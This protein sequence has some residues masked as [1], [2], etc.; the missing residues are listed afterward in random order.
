MTSPRVV[1]DLDKIDHNA[2]ALVVR[3]ARSGISVSGVTKAVLADPEIAGVLLRAGVQGLGD[4]HIENIE[5]LRRAHGQSEIT[6]IRTPMISQADRIVAHADISFNT[7]LAVIAAL[8]SAAQEQSKTHG[9]VLMVELGD[10]REGV[11]P[12]NLLAAVEA[13]RRFPNIVFKGIGAN[14]ACLNGVVPGASNMAE[15]SSLADKIDAKF[16][17]I[18]EIV[19]GGNSANINWAMSGAETGR[20]NNL[21][22]GEAIFF[23]CEALYRHPI[24]GLY[25]DAITLVGEVIEAKTKPPLPW[26]ATAQNA[27]GETTPVCDRGAV[28]RV[29][30]A[31]GRQDTEPSGLTPPPGYEIIGA[32]SDHLVL[33]AGKHSVRVGDALTFQVNYSAFLKAMTSPLVG[34][35]LRPQAIDAYVASQVSAAHL[36]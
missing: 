28:S 11:M 17:P 15:L 4:S 2:R 13:T 9:V 12:D 18:T 26:G 10:L 29:I 33:D 32:S 1:I 8:S 24:E 30:V 16:G 25:Q 19:S 35:V 7:E 36:P 21:R 14:L 23:G 31:I 20:I 27:F 5:K 34:Q 22:L 6:L 3:L